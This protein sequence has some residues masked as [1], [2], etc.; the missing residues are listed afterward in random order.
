M[1]V[2]DI[3][4]CSAQQSALIDSGASISVLCSREFNKIKTDPLI[5]PCKSNL[6]IKSVTGDKLDIQGC[7]SLP[8]TIGNKTIH[9]PFH[10]VSQNLPSQYKAIIGYDL[11]KN[12]KFTL[13]LTKDILTSTN[14]TVKIRD[15]NTPK[16]NAN[17]I[18]YA[19]LQTKCHL[20]PHETKIVKLTLHAPLTTGDNI[21]LTPSLIN[22]AIQLQQS[23]SSVDNKK[24]T[25]II[26]SNLTSQKI[27]LN[28]N[29]RIA[30]INKDI[31]IRDM[32][33]IK[34][35]RKEEL[36]PSDFNLEHLD[37]STKKQLLDL[38]FEFSDIF[39]K[40]VY[41]IGRTQE[42]TPK[43]HVNSENLPSTRPYPVPIALRE[44]LRKQ[45]HELEDANLIE[46]SD[47]YISF[48]LIMIKKRNPTNDPA[49]QRWRL[50]VDFRKL[51]SNTNYQHYPLPLTTQLLDN[52]RGSTYY[53]SLDLSSSFW[54]IPLDPKD[55]DFTTF[56]SIYGSYRH[57]VLPQGLNVS[58]G[59]LQKLS[60]KILAPLAHLNISNY[61]DDYCL[62][63]N[64]VSQMLYKLRQ[65][66]LQFRQFGLTL[67]PHKCTFLLPKITFLGHSLDK[68]GVAPIAENI[69]RIQ[70]F[71][72]PNT[73]RKVRRWIGMVGYYRRFI[74]NFS[75]IC[76]PLT[77]LTR[78]RQKFKWTS[79]AQTA[80][81]NLKE[82]LSNFPI[83]AHPDFSKQFILS[84]DS[85]DLAI[86]GMLGQRDDDGIIHPISYY[87][88][89]LTNQELKYPIMEKELKAIV[90]SVKAFK[91]YLYGRKFIVRCDN[92]ALQSIRSL[93]S[94]ANRVARWILYLSEYDFTFEK[95]SG[96]DNHAADIFSRDFHA[97]NTIQIDLPT[98]ET[99][100]L[101]QSKDPKIQQLIQKLNNVRSI[102]TRSEE[103][104]FFRDNLLMHTAYIPKPSGQQIVEQIVIP[105]KLKPNILAFGHASHNG[106]FKTYQ[107]IRDF[108]Y[109]NNMYTDV[110]HYVATCQECFGFKT[111]KRYAPVPLQRH[112][113]PTRP[114]QY[115]SVDIIGKLPTTAKNN[116]Y[117]ITFLDHFTKY[118]KIYPMQ[119]QTA[120]TT[121]DKL[122]KFICTF[123][124]PEML[125]SDLGSNFKSEL[126]QTVANRLGIKKLYTTPLH[127][128]SNGQNEVTHKALRKSL[129]IFARETAQWDE[130]IPFYE[131]C[132]NSNYH[133]ATNEKPCFLLLGYDV[134]LPNSVIQSHN[135]PTYDS[136][137]DYVEKKTTQ[138]QT[139]YRYVHENL[140]QAA[141]KQE[142]YLNPKSKPRNFYPGQL[143][144]IY[145][146]EMD[147]HNRTVKKRNYKGPMRI[148]TKYNAVNYTVIDPAQRNSK[149][150]KVHC[151]RLIP[152]QERRPELEYNPTIESPNSSSQ[153]NFSQQKQPPPQFSD[154]KASNQTPPFYYL[155][156]TN[157]T[158]TPHADPVVSPSTS[159]S[160]TTEIYDVSPQVKNTHIPPT[161]S[162][163]LRST[164]QSNDSLPAISSS[165]S[166]ADKIY[167]WALQ[168]TESSDQPPSTI[169]FLD[170]ISDALN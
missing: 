144:Y 153:L 81:D 103:N 31:Q 169:K 151:A 164:N 162:Y 89:K 155:V 168:A 23:V 154:D 8:V 118:L 77:D 132:Y 29:T 91:Q 5:K 137:P 140:T 88:R 145:S 2:I 48:P 105:D 107:Y 67:N 127:P 147:R 22:P 43:F 74:P 25:E 143:V 28:K 56:N 165:V 13:D 125:L 19:K 150:Q 136:I 130:H 6:I 131:L 114:M 93:E 34:Q 146:P 35:L 69:V 62:G 50:V 72:P 98:L 76:A 87:S 59:T 37:N 24:T 1:P 60:D 120:K 75:Q 58:P 101:E 78:G 159:H 108:Y 47:S 71:P 126:F 16:C 97:L 122:Y 116:S 65:L 46:K 39:S 138:L 148:V 52:L 86:A 9:H 61:I 117:A 170:R 30:T 160:D 68:N 63:S 133:S 15:A 104:Y 115:V 21:L 139:A 14:T 92:A 121:A 54:Q 94:P 7:Y 17:S 109:W 96:A 157:D 135:K 51:N 124:T 57:T 123:G 100:Q 32:D 161:H 149:P 141:E 33:K 84:T 10:I 82:K 119:D 99:I 80:F 106:H 102:L 163:N 42:V 156:T 129:A 167:N 44:E 18:H 95:I 3:K 26:I 64:S 38:L 113:I 70:E 11:L 90:D 152:F 73:V 134:S 128:S 55:R 53:S 45:L 20:N 79:Q 111:P 166:L 49:K 12:H 112:F 4:I 66:F 158:D 36:H 27:A 83:L 40:R 142:N 41:T 110:K 85:S